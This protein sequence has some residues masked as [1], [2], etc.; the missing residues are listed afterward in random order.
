M[1]HSFK[2]SYLCVSRSRFICLM[3]WI[4]LCPPPPPIVYHLCPMQLGPFHIWLQAGVM[5]FLLIWLHLVICSVFLR[6]DWKLFCSSYFWFYIVCCVWCS[7]TCES[8]FYE[9]VI[10]I[11]AFCSNKVRLDCTFLPWK[12]S[13]LCVE[14]DCLGF[15]CKSSCCFLI[16]DYAAMK[17]VLLFSSYNFVGFKGPLVCRTCY[18]EFFFSHLLP[19]IFTLY[20]DSIEQKCHSPPSGLKFHAILL[21]TLLH[22]N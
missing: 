12:C 3:F 1:I 19:L 20:W 8:C 16:W 11:P 9:S 15:S 14:G 13:D 21:T 5:P 17:S 6:S 22:L 10:F 7:D 4:C 18:W 2:L